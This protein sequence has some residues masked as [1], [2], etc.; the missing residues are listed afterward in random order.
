MPFHVGTFFQC[1]LLAI[2]CEIGDKTFLAITAFAIWCPWCGLRKGSSGLV[3]LEYLLLWGGASIAMVARTFL[4]WWGV[5]PFGWDGF[6]C[7]VGASLLFLCAIA[8]TVQW[9]RK[10]QDQGEMDP[11]DEGQI[12]ARPAADAGGSEQSDPEAT[13]YGAVAV[14]QKSLL[15]EPKEG[16]CQALT[17]ALFLPGTVVLFAEGADRSQGVLLGTEHQ[18]ADLV[19][20]AS[21]GFITSTL[22]AVLFGYVISKQ[23]QP[24]WMLFFLTCVLWAL[25]ISCTRD[26]IVRLLLGS[27]PR[28][29]L[30][31]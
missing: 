18:R 27:I 31:R 22:M 24:K 21:F 28:V 17:L 23:V 26:A 2:F 7:V 9:R 1:W 25:T 20:G 15:Q 4:L 11:G 30:S 6:S 29:G 13:G 3:A 12:A 19:L 8:A 5:D 16:W 14:P 10:V